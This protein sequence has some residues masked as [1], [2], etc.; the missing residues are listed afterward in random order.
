MSIFFS[1]D[2]NARWFIHDQ[3]HDLILRSE[4]ALDAH[5]EITISY[6]SK[7]NEE[8]LYLYGFTFP[9]N[10]HDRVTLPVSLPPDDSLLQ[11]KFQRIQELQLPPR[12]TLNC[13]GHLTNESNH[14]VKIL[15]AQSL[16][17][18][19]QDHQY[20]TPYLLNLLNDYLTALNDCDTDEKF[21]KY[22]L[23]SQ[24]MIVHKAIENL[25]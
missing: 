11:E 20:S 21:V 25:K 10:P 9:S 16:E 7:S 14:L 1:L 19:D 15:S 2:A 24:K 5:E 22:Y 13:H 8:L 23:D 3:T 17:T 4:R 12:L 18:L 6:G